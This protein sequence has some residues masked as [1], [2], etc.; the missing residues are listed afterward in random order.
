[1]GLEIKICDSCNGT[2]MRYN[3]DIFSKNNDL[4]NCEHCD[5]SGRLRVYTYKMT[6]PFD[7]NESKAL[8]IDERIWTTIHNAETG[9]SDVID[10]D[11]AS[12]K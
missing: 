12:K 7:F 11:L 4:V 5:G 2:G 1:M 10:E 6:L 9:V 3:D 8:A